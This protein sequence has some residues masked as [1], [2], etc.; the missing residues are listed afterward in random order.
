MPLTP[1]TLLPLNTSLPAQIVTRQ[2]ELSASR[3][4]L[5]VMPT[6]EKFAVWPAKYG[7]AST[8]VGWGP[9]HL[10]P[11][12]RMRSKPP[13]TYRLHSAAVPGVLPSGCTE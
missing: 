13:R 4:Q 5:L 1:D 10:M 8:M 6:P 9:V 3:A 7:K 2:E 12:L 11:A